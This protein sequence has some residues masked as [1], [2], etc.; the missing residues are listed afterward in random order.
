MAE[1]PE[2]KK[3]QEEI[4]SQSQAF[5][6]K[7]K[8]RM[9][10]VLTDEQWARLLA[11]IDNPPAHAQV[12]GKRLRERQ[13]ENAQTGGG[14]IPGPGAWQPGDPIPAQYRQERNTRSRF[15]R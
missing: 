2:Y 11:L 12:L 8:I 14:Y 3:I 7:F 15:P 5:S 10:D 6:E 1:D 13:G 9:F 4:L